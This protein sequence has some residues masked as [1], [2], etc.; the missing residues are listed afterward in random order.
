MNINNTGRSLILSETSEPLTLK[1][2]DEFVVKSSEYLFSKHV[3]IIGYV[4]EPGAGVYV[5]GVIKNI[6]NEFS[7]VD[8]WDF[9]E[10]VDTT[11]AEVIWYM[12]YF[13]KPGPALTKMTKRQ[14]LL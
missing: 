7:F 8:E 11:D 13:A 9:K 1:E 3:P 6:L 10:Y 4:Y 12:D 5:V 14:E 2:I